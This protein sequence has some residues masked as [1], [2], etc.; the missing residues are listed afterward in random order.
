MESRLGSG[1]GLGLGLRLM[2]GS[3][4]QPQMLLMTIYGYS[5]WSDGHIWVYCLGS[6]ATFR[7]AVPARDSNRVRVRVR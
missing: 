1:L 6:G 3:R 5:V 7:F 4:S 2:L